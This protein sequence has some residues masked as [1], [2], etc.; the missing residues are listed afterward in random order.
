MNRRLSRGLTLIE[1][2]A[3]FVI[4]AIVATVASTLMSR[5]FKSYFLARDIT[6][7][8][9]QVRVAF[10]RMTRELRQIRSPIAAD[11]DIASAAQVRFFDIDGNGVCFYRDAVNNRLM[12]SS[13]G[14]ST[15]CGTTS[16]QPLSDFVTGL[17]LVYY[18]ND[19]INAAAVATE[20]YYVT[21]RVTVVDNDVTDTLRATIH[22]RNFP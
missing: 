13:D 15:A 14:P 2:V 20:V 6:N 11:L 4:F 12:R 5:M 21:V 10:E 1:M 7:S 17:T 18:K 3:A 8:D 19:G 9:S 16:A 22:P